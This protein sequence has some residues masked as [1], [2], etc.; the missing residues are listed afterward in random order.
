MQKLKEIYGNV[1]PVFVKVDLEK[2]A[3]SLWE[4][5]FSETRDELQA[6]W[7]FVENRNSKETLEIWAVAWWLCIKWF[8]LH[9]MDSWDSFL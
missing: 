7:P 8:E 6:E 3:V 9:W 1:L 5:Y 2:Y 4:M